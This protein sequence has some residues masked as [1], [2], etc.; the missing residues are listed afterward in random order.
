M[1]IR[2]STFSFLAIL[3]T[4]R[5]LEIDEYSGAP[6]AQDKAQS[7]NAAGTYR[8]AIIMAAKQPKQATSQ[9]LKL[10]VLRGCVTTLHC[11]TITCLLY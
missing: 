7:E 6:M 5:R 1:L 2:I 4:T 10:R 3:R 11:S 8:V 9:V